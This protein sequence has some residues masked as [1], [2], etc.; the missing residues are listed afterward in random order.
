MQENDYILLLSKRFAGEISPAESTLLD[1]WMAESPENAQLAAELRQAWEHS[2]NYAKA[3]A[4]DL[5]TDF[6]RVQARIRAERPTQFRLTWGRKMLR[7]AAAVALL[8]CAVWSWQRFGVSASPE[9]VFTAQDVEKQQVELPDGS[10][11]WLRNG[12]AISFPEGFSAKERRVKLR[13]EAY[14]EVAHNAAKPF[15]VELEHGGEVQ[16][17]GTEFDVRQ[18]GDERTVLVR[19]GKVRFSF[20]AE[21]GSVLLAAGERAAHRLST[22]VCEKTE[23][24]SFNELSW[25]TG[26]LEFV[27]TPLWQVMRDLE[28]FYRVK[29][30]L[31]NPL[32]ADCPHTSPLTNQPIEKVLNALAQTH[33][34]KVKKLGESSFRLTGGVCR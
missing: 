10:R 31:E 22:N 6:Q 30:E 1:A 27:R 13:G 8:A 25:Q 17:L 15:R 24:A 4:P 32:M 28:G 34:L 20:D 16:V 14:F 11:A 2:G 21:G 18:N 29:V 12:A 23:A 33:G 9:M 5:E 7:A 26:G 19:A 3:F